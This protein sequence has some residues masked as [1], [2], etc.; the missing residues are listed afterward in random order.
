MAEADVSEKN[1]MPSAEQQGG[2]QGQ[3]AQPS[4]Q[5]A[6]AMQSRG[7]GQ[8]RGGLARR[9]AFLPSMFAVSPR[10]LLSLNP[11]E[12]MRRFTE[13]MDRTFEDAGLS[14]GAGGGE[15]QSWVPP[16]DI[17]ERDNNIVVR[18]ELPGVENEDVTV[19]LT[20][21][22][23]VIRGERR[24]DHEER[25]RGIY[26]S[27]STYGQ[28]YRLIPL[29]DGVN[30]EQARAQLNNG[31]LEIT[32]PMSEAQGRQRNIP[33]ESGGGQATQTTGGQTQTATGGS[34]RK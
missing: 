28:F 27:E 15:T 19:S 16:V 8:Q 31:M 7:Q 5:Q 12:L 18:M 29:P 6:G 13:E 33:I 17:F 11:F 1:Q 2:Q 3:T 10:H 9:R 21:D 25:R 34:G 23:L 14:R 22:G 24:L 20:D 26:V 32:I 4:G 30:V